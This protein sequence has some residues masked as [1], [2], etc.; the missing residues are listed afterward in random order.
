MRKYALALVLLGISIAGYAQRDGRIGQQRALDLIDPYRRALAK[1]IET[2]D[3]SFSLTTF[4]AEGQIGQKWT[5]RVVIDFLNRRAVIESFEKKGE[6]AERTVLLG[7]TGFVI[8]S[9]RD[10]TRELAASE[11]AVYN[12][13]FIGAARNF[14]PLNLGSLKYEAN[15]KYGDVVEGQQIIS[16]P[17]PG[18]P[19]TLLSNRIVFD[20]E[21][22]IIAVVSEQSTKPQ[23]QITRLTEP[24]SPEAFEKFAN[25]TIYTVDPGTGKADRVA[26]RQVENFSINQPVEEALFK[27]E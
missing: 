4:G 26:E 10:R 3:E 12:Q 23:L 24:A 22:R 25:S 6:L 15:A 8:D 21:G 2:L 13:M 18:S 17:L 20:R 14:L 1:P 5:G 11:L 9:D 27:I 16:T 19:R 7:D